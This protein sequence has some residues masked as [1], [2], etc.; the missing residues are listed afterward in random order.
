MVASKIDHLT[1]I[2]K[3]LDAGEDPSKVK[4]EAK[5]F[6]SSITE[7]DLVE[8]EQQL[9]QSNTPPEQ[10]RHLCSVHMEMLGDEQNLLK[11]S[12][13]QGHVITT[14][15]TEHE[16][17]LSFLDSLEMVNRSI[18]TTGGSS[19][20]LKQLQNIAEH[21]LGAE[22]H[23]QREEQV[24]FP[25]LEIRGFF[26]PPQVMRMEHETLRRYK[27]EI[28]QI[29][30]NSDIHDPKVKAKLDQ[31]SKTLIVKLRDHIF[32]ENSILYPT[33][34]QFIKE[35]T[36]NKLKIQCDQVGYCCFTPNP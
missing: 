10:I 27:R 13:G 4:N 21:L 25:E 16:V 19:E 24:L 20:D 18:Q 26:G 8:A 23:H 29:A 31:T 17:I 9:M 33:A 2:L 5:T 1:E 14:L 3:R 11:T 12:L 36:W 32:K 22:P 34:L 15:M 35:E 28:K 6:L 7:T 30:E